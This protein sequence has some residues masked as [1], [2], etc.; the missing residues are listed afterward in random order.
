MG[1][2]EG[3]LGGVF[4]LSTSNIACTWQNEEFGQNELHFG[5][6]ITIPSRSWLSGALGVGAV[7]PKKGGR[8]R[9]T[10]IPNHNHQ[11]THYR[12]WLTTFCGTEEGASGLKAKEGVQ[13][14]WVS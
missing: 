3:S 8:N 9:G 2:W 5:R 10:S 13:N 4:G 6:A 12:D 14:S 11:S 7:H 1:F